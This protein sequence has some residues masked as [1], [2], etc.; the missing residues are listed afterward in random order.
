MIHF[1]CVCGIMSFF[2]HFCIDE[3]AENEE[4]YRHNLFTQNE[5]QVFPSKLMKITIA[6]ALTS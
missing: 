2:A 1:N 6:S 5:F 4:F 3:N